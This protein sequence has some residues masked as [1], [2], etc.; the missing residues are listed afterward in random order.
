MRL[1]LSSN[2]HTRARAAYHEMTLSMLAYNR[3]RVMDPFFLKQVRTPPTAM[4]HVGT[5]LTI[6]LVEP[7]VAVL[8]HNGHRAAGWT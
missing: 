1:F 3:T 2:R 4:S 5:R 7:G 6:S 8:R